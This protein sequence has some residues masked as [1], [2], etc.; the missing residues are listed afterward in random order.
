MNTTKGTCVCDGEAGPPT[1][2]LHD[3]ATTHAARACGALYDTYTIES[4][5]SSL[6]ESAY[7]AAEAIVINDVEDG[8]E[9]GECGVGGA[10]GAC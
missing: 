1:S 8:A 3:K 7:A 4:T 10:I 2:G 6:S 9:S 5:S